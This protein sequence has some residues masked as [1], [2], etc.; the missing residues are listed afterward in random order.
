MRDLHDV[1]IVRGVT[2]IL[3]PRDPLMLLR[4]SEVELPLDPG[5]V[6][7]LAAHVDGGLHD[8]QARAAVFAVRREDRACGVFTKLLGARPRLIELSQLLARRL[9]TI[10]EGDERVSDGTLAVV[11]CRAVDADGTTVQFPAVLKLDPSTTLRT[12]MDADPVTHKQRVRF[13]VDSTTLPSKREKIQ[14]CAFA[15]TVD[16]AAEYELLVVDRQSGPGVVSRFWITDFLGA[17]LVFDAPERTKRLYRALWSA[18]NAVEQ[19]LDAAQLAALDLVID[20]T[21]VQASVNL[22]N[23]VAALP[24]PE[25]IRARIDAALSSTLPDREFDLD[26]GV[27]SQFLRRRTFRGD[28]ALRLSVR[29][30]F[31]KMIHVED[32]D[33]SN[34]ENRLRRVWFETR[35]WKEN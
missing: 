33:P 23:L 15:R 30:E 9:Y 29:A 13:E 2:H 28:N 7:I 27:A 12:V 25:P 10:A 5:V 21:V 34:E 17:E 11:V 14:K 26:P 35:T 20:G 32:V 31:T 19:D 1:T 16:P 6:D 24:V 4:L 3:A 8:A 18:R 22:D